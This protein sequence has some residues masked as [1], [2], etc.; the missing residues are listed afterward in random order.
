MSLSDLVQV[1]ASL[2]SQ[3]ILRRTHQS[4]IGLTIDEICIISGHLQV[5]HHLSGERTMRQLDEHS[6]LLANILSGQSNLQGLLQLQTSSDD[7]AR[8]PAGS[9]VTATS[10]QSSGSIIHIRARAFQPARFFCAPQCRC[11]CHNIRSFRSPSLF[12]EAIGKLFIGYSGCPLGALRRCTDT[13]CLSQST[14]RACVHYIFPSW[15]FAKVLSIILK[16][17]FHS[18]INMSLTV[19]HVVSKGAE[20]FRL[21]TLDDVDGLRR[22]FSMGLASPDDSSDGGQTA[23]RV[24]IF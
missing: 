21:V 12:H 8:I 5:N 2:Y 20:I 6:R 16:S 18:E 11:S 17:D 24:C 23:L 19:R 4:R 13:S 14:Y 9:L 15:F 1:N 22:L 7:N 10:D 3:L